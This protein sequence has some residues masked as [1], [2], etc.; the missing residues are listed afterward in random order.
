MLLALELHRPEDDD[1]LLASKNLGFSALELR[2]RD[3]FLLISYPH[4]APPCWFPRNLP[5]ATG[6]GINY[7]RREDLKKKKKGALM[8][9][10]SSLLIIRGMQI[11]TIMRYHL[12]Q[13]RMA[14]IKSVPI[15]NAGEGNPL[16]LL[17]EM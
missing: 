8:K 12:T 10:C 4:P 9:R 13:V 15:I 3:R 7:P 17:V 5:T 1:H 6:S 14:M 2:N 11:K 16:T